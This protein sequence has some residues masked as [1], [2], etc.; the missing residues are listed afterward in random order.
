M[1]V[2]ATEARGSGHGW[3]AV[4]EFAV[5]A[6]QEQ[7]TTLVGLH[8]DETGDVA[9]RRARFQRMGFEFEGL[10]G[11]ASVDTLLAGDSEGRPR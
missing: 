4:Q 6:S 3:R 11:V 5:L 1:I 10:L 2:I 8:L 7:G 9:G